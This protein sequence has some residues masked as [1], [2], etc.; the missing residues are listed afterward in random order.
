MVNNSGEYRFSEVM[1]GP[2]SENWMEMRT[3]G[4]PMTKRNF[5]VAPCGDQES[6]IGGFLVHDVY[7]IVPR[8]NPRN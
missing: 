3:G 2:P 4:I 5:Y 8:G 7:V 1:G 6:W